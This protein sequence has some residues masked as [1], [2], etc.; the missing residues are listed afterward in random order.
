MFHAT[1][2]AFCGHDV[3]SYRGFSWHVQWIR[4]V[5][6]VLCG[7]DSIC[8]MCMDLTNAF[9][10]AGAMNSCWLGLHVLLFSCQA[11]RFV[12]FVSISFRND[13][14]DSIL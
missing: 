3:V 2:A 11:Q 4:D 14:R 13:G 5:V 6:D 7:G 8:E 12:T 9:C 10:G 1:C